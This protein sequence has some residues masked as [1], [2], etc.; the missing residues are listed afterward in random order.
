MQSGIMP[1]VVASG[2]AVFG[3]FKG[4]LTEQFVIQALQDTFINTEF[5]YWTSD[6]SAEV[7]FVFADKENII[8][9]EVKSG[10]NLKARSLKVFMEKYAT[11]IA[12]RT[13]PE[14]SR[15]EPKLLD[16]PLYALWNMQKYIKDAV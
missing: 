1:A 2:N 6:A 10:I 5:Y 15:I 16:I 11:K 13:S 3:E 9:V 14:K 7:E 12:V 4:A 8:P